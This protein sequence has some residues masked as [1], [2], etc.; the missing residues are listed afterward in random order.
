MTST[1]RDTGMW[2][3]AQLFS[4]LSGQANRLGELASVILVAGQTLRGSRRSFP[5]GLEP[6]EHRGTTHSRVG[7]GCA[8]AP[9]GFH[10]LDLPDELFPLP[11]YGTVV[12]E[13]LGQGQARAIIADVAAQA[14]DAPIAKLVALLA[15]VSAEHGVEVP[16]I[17]DRQ[18][19]AVRKLLAPRVELAG[20]VT[21]LTADRMAQENR[22]LVTI[23]GE[24]DG[25]ESVGMTVQAIVIDRP[26]KMHAGFLVARR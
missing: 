24:G 3:P 6:R 25:L 21:A 1:A 2:H 17:D 18:V 12:D 9:A 23:R 22:L 16:G 19:T 26:V 14:G 8:E 13:K 4:R 10:L 11:S 20:T 7:L 15:D 5:Q